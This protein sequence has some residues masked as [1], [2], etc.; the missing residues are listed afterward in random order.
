MQVECG[1]AQGAASDIGGRRPG[2]AVEP[3]PA[4]G[5][6]F[7]VAE[8]VGGRPERGYEDAV[9]QP[10]RS[11][12]YLTEK[13][14]STPSG[15]QDNDPAPDRKWRTNAGFDDG[16]NGLVQGAE[17]GMLRDLPNPL[18]RYFVVG[19]GTRLC[20]NRHGVSVR[21]VTSV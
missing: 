12:R 10:N 17:G 8:P 15:L 1:C 3:N 20:V 18:R 14:G 7:E 16:D 11:Q 21:A 6:G 2:S 13:P 5:P 4:L 19:L 9:A